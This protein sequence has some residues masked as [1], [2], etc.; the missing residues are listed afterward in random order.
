MLLA[1]EEEEQSGSSERA[2]DNT[3]RVVKSG[4][5]VFAELL[6]DTGHKHIRYMVL[7]M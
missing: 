1:N 5:Q 7:T 6:N 2:S 4:I 3:S